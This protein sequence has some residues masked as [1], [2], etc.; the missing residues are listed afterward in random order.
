[1]KAV[2]TGG[3]GMLGKKLGK[4]LLARSEITKIVLFDVVDPGDA[5]K[6]PRIEVVVGEVFDAATIAKMTCPSS[7]AWARSAGTGTSLP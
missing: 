2:V 6:D 1:M 7:L 5:P 3:T 4:A